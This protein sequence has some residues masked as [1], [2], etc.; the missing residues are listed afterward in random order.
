MFLLGDHLQQDAAR[1]VVLR[2]LVDDDEVDALEYQG[3]DIVERDV[4]ALNRVV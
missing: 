1:D 2:L 4:F 3:P